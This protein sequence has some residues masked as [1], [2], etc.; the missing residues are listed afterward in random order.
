M[1][2]NPLKAFYR[3]PK[4]Y[5]SLPSKGKFYPEGTLVG[6]PENLAV[7]GMTAMDEIILKTPDALFSGESVVQVIQSCIPGIAQAWAMPTIDIDAALIAIRIATY[8]AKMPMTFKC[9]KCKEENAIDL[10]LSTTLDYF[11]NLQYEDYIHID[12][13]T[14]YIKP[15][16]YKGQTEFQKKQYELQKMLA[17]SYD[18]MKEEERSKHINGIFEKLSALQTS[19]FKS[20]IA[21]VEADET[22]VDNKDQIQE[23]INNSDAEFFAKI[24]SHLEKLSDAWKVQ[25]Q[26]ATCASCETENKITI[27][28]DYSSFFARAS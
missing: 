10:D 2:D 17:G 16:T 26:T 3:Q 18:D 12:P 22:V 28:L 8:G 13:L 19:V 5:L 27:G 15:L 9:K 14:V 25:D 7:F 4:I 24:K 21:S 1:T 20:C 11:I 6:D 23:W